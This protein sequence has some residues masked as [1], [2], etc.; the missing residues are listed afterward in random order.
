MEGKLRRSSTV[1]LLLIIA[2]FLFSLSLSAARPATAAAGNGAPSR[3][4]PANGHLPPNSTVTS[5]A[6]AVL[7]KLS[8]DLQKAAANP[9]AGTSQLVVA[10]TTTGSG[11][12]TPGTSTRSRWKTPSA[13]APSA[14][15]S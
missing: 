8:P 3:P 6:D 10:R 7:P 5:A 11:W 9:A 2:T 12:P 1:L 14:P 13:T 4:L 15:A